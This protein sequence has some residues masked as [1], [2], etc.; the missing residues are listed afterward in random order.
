MKL[1]GKVALVTG[2]AN[3]IGEATVRRL[4]QAG[5]TV[6]IADVDVERGEA[7]AA[8][9]GAPHRFVQLDVADEGQ[10]REV[11]NGVKAHEGFLHIL[12]LNAGILVRPLGA[13]AGDP[14]MNWLTAENYRRVQRVNG[15]GV[16]YGVINGFPLIRESGGGII[17]AN[18]STAAVDFF[19]GDPTY[20]VTKAGVIALV[21]SLAAEFDAAGVRICAVCPGSVDTRIYP[22][23]RRA[24]RTGANQAIPASPYYL[25]NAVL[26]VID[27][28][29]S[30]EVWF[31]RTDDKG[32]FNYAPPRLPRAPVSVAEASGQRF[33][34]ASIDGEML[35]GRPIA[36]FL[37]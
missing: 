29:V 18:G 11:I 2:A 26:T 36:D 17:L 34:A 12:F 9:L 31:A 19:A 10:W 13:P 33:V 14:A 6:V 5:A 22:K 20:S 27:R 1:R 3:G 28:G 15:D 21:Q 25:A 16:M 35:D 8:E 32:F 23:D 37:A 7:I 4:A 30:G 24:E